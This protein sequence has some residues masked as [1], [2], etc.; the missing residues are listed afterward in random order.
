MPRRCATDLFRLLLVV[1]GLCD[2]LCA[3]MPPLPKVDGQGTKLSLVPEQLFT[4]TGHTTEVCTVAY[5]PDGKRFASASNKEVKVWD[6]TTGKELFSYAIKGTNVYGL[7]FSPDSSRLA[8]GISKQ[9]KILDTRTGEEVAT[10]LG[11]AHFLFRLAFSPDGK[12][13]AASG[14]SNNNTG[15][16]RVWE[17]ATSKQLFCFNGHSHAV[18]TVAYSPD[19]KLLASGGGATSGSKPGELKLWDMT[20]GAE[21]V[22]LAG[23]AEN[24]YGLAFSPDGRRLASCSGVGRGVNKPGT[25]K[26]WEVRSGQEIAEYGGHTGPIYAVTFS[27]DGRRIIT[28]SGDKIL[29]VRDAFSFEELVRWQGHANTIFSLALSTDGRRLLTGGQDK[30]VN[31]WDMTDSRQQVH[32]LVPMPHDVNTYWNDLRSADAAKAYRS[33][34]LLADHPDKTLPLFNKHIQPVSL[35]AAQKKQLGTWLEQLDHP[36]YA[37]REKAFKQLDDL[38]EALRTP[39]SNALKG[40]LTPEVRERIERLLDNQ[41]RLTPTKLASLRALEVLEWMDD[42][43]AEVLLSELAKGEA[44]AVLTREAQATLKRLQKK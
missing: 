20:T 7:A 32:E 13:L 23:H 33:M 28:G 19:G 1:S 2:P 37:V 29:Q 16:I 12:Q 21:V 8:F 27:N 39:L 15:D 9:V 44:E 10:I 18:L 40:E 42:P 6:S 17:I 3:Q 43:K 38:G 26:I 22:T 36:R 11:A 30:A 4:L 14:G 5:A 24:V 25:V 41:Q 35:T 34:R 31:V